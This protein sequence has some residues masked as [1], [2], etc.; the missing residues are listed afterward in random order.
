V[1][2]SITFPC[3][4]K[5]LASTSLN[6]E[7]RHLSMIRIWLD[8]E[9]EN[10]L[11]QGLSKKLG[12]PLD[13][14]LPADPIVD[15]DICAFFGVREYI[16][17]DGFMELMTGSEL[18]VS[19]ATMYISTPRERFTKFKVYFKDQPV[20]DILRLSGVGVDSYRGLPNKEAL[21]IRLWSVEPREIIDPFLRL[22]NV[23]LVK[24]E[25]EEL[26]EPGIPRKVL[27]RGEEDMLRLFLNKGL[28]DLPTRETSLKALAQELNMSDSKLSLDLRKIQNKIFAE[29]LRQ[30]AYSSV[31]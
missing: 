24:W 23:R 8:I 20:K 3:G 18:Y 11:I 19:T 1:E 14:W 17:K 10:C 28:F 2:A 30:T 13:L 9:H 5:R 27:T 12:Q 7:E 6:I 22:P 15:D 31:F 26:E 21:S 25:R 29:Y 16:D 4:E